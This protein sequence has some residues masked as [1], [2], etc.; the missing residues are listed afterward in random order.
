M[1]NSVRGKRDL[2]KA[3]QV[4]Q[5]SPFGEPL[6]HSLFSLRLTLYHVGVLLL[7]FVSIVWSGI[8]G[9]L[10]LVRWCLVA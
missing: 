4:Y 2:P 1:K 9:I 7:H 10:F 6:K 5:V 3:G 8:V